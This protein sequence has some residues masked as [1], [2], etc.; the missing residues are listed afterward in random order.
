MAEKHKLSDIK[1]VIPALITCFAEDGEFDEKRERAEGSDH[2][3][4]SGTRRARSSASRG[5]RPA[6]VDCRTTDPILAQGRARP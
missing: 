1:G 5:R 6:N 2:P 4:A 3:L